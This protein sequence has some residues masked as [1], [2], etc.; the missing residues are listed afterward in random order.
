MS[1]ILGLSRYFLNF[2]DNQGSISIG[3]EKEIG[4]EILEELGSELHLVKSLMPEL[5][6]VIPS[7]KRNSFA[8]ESYSFEAGRKRWEYAFRVLTR[9]LSSHFS[10][11]INVLYD[12]QWTD[13]SSLEVI[14]FLISECAD[15]NRMLS[16]E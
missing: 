1:R 4:L 9:V 10:P 12:L 8:S 13:A 15:D 2:S 14:D 5:E 6:G 16:L 3:R 11:L 7:S